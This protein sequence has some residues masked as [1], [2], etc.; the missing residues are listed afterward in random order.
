MI[1]CIGFNIIYI[2]RNTINNTLIY[3]VAQA[4][5]I[6]KVLQTQSDGFSFDLQLWYFPLQVYL[7]LN[8]QY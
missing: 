4:T 3:V 8:H 5:Y 6:F 2:I 1:G 7:H